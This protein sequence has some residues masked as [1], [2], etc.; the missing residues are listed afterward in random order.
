M[1]AGVPPGLQNQ[2]LGVSSVRGGFDSHILPPIRNG[3]TP[4][5]KSN[6]FGLEECPRSIA[7]EGRD[8]PRSILRF[9]QDDKN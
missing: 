5:L 4:P 8:T 2:S 1:G 6:A 9:T 7:Y 3:D